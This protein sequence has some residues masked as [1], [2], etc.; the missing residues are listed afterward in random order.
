MVRS[1]T[2]AIDTRVLPADRRN[3][4][5]LSISQRLNE[6]GHVRSISAGVDVRW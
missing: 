1:A 3:S 4:A 6:P 5:R 2:A